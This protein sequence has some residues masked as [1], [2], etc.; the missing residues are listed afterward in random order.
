MTKSIKQIGYSFS[1]ELIV[2]LWLWNWVT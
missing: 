2:S 1:Y